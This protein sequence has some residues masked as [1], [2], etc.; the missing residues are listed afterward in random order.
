MLMK[1]FVVVKH[2]ASIYIAVIN[3]L[4]LRH[5]FGSFLLH[6]GTEF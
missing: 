6:L 3:Y 1:L 5:A 2:L 4:C